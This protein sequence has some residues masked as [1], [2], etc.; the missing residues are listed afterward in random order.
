MTR[1]RPYF[2]HEKEYYPNG[3]LKRVATGAY[4]IN[5]R[6]GTLKYGGAIF[7]KD[8]PCESWSRKEGLRRA[9][10]RFLQNPVIIK[11]GPL[12]TVLGVTPHMTFSN[13]R[14]LE[15]FIRLAF[16]RY[17]VEYHPDHNPD[18]DPHFQKYRDEYIQD[19]FL[20][21]S[22]TSRYFQEIFVNN[23]NYVN[24]YLLLWYLSGFLL[25]AFL[26]TFA[27]KLLFLE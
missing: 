4:Y 18:T 13:Y 5:L 2:F 6:T 12:H 10:A 16:Y 14:T 11:F 26:V 27:L 24:T 15:S 19:I 25:Q 8:E 1:G 20:D 3:N 9:T 17:G 7:T 23:Y 21:Q 22:E